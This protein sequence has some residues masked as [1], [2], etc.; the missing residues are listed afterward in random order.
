MTT[1]P[2]CGRVADDEFVCAGCGL[3]LVGVQREEAPSTEVSLR[4]LAAF[5]VLICA[6]A[7]GTAFVLLRQG[8]GG[9]QEP[10]LAAPLGTDSSPGPAPNGQGWTPRGT[11]RSG[12][13]ASATD[14]AST[15]AASTTAKSSTARRSTS[16]AA[17]TSTAAARRST[18]TS[19]TSAAPR[20]TTSAARTSTT[21]TNPASTPRTVH[22][23]K[24]SACGQHC[25]WLVVNLSGFSGGAHTIVCWAGHGGLFGR[26]T[27]SSQTSSGCKYSH[28]H[29]AVW[30]VVDGSYRSNTVAW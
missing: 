7:A 20:P 6:L 24:G 3:L 11:S 13:P 9:G 14:S 30:V 4:R 29:D 28:P 10:H 5:V 26:Y 23:T 16:A 25:Y 17:S 12:A 27:T 18:A 8:G 21:T 15:K 2:R 19:S 22:L 1:C